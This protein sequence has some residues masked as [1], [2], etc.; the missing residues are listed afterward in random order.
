MMRRRR[1][2]NQACIH[3][4]RGEGASDCRV[5]SAGTFS[6][7]KFFNHQL[8]APSTPLARL[9]RDARARRDARVQ[10]DQEVPKGQARRR[11]QAPQGCRQS[12]AEEADGRQEEGAQGQRQRK[13]RRPRR[14]S[15]KEAKDEWRQRRQAGRDVHGPILPGRLPD[16]RDEEEVDQAKDGQAQTHT[17]RRGCRPSL[18]RRHARCAQRR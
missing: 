3:P 17:S 7:P 13:G 10:G 9:P 12:Q 8:H 14:R 4:P 5:L 15:C 1:Q 16:S 2:L 11:H 6:R 18:R